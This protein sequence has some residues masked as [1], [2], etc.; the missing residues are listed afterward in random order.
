MRRVETEDYW[1]TLSVSE[2][3][4][5]AWLNAFVDAMMPDER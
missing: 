3:P 1:I 2:K 4:V 5:K